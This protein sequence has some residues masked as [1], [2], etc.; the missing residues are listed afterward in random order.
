[1]KSHLGQGF[2]YVNF[3]EKYP[4][5]KSS[6][7]TIAKKLIKVNESKGLLQKNI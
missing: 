7:E 6:Q 2:S 5:S 3:R 4:N 1:M